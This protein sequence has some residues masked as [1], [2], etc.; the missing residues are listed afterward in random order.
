[1]FLTDIEL[2]FRSLTSEAK[3]TVM[4]PA[5]AYSSIAFFKI[6][7]SGTLHMNVHL[8]RSFFVGSRYSYLFGASNS[9]GFRLA[10]LLSGS[11]LARNSLLGPITE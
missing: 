7:K 11:R 8:I 2:Y 3:A 5:D 10:N 6:M 9:L 4:H 1:M